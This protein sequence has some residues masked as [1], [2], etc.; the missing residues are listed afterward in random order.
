MREITSII[1]AL[2]A[3]VALAACGGGGTCS[4]SNCAG[5]CDPSGQCQLP[6]D[7]HCGLRGAACSACVGGQRCES[8]LGQCEF[9]GNGTGAGNGAGS[10]SSTTTSA[11]TSG[12]SA[13][14]SG[15]TSTSAGASSGSTGGSTT[16]SISTSSGSTGASSTGSSSGFTSGTSTS[17]SS[18]STGTS[19]SGTSTTTS[20]TTT[21]TSTTGG[22]TTSG[23]TTG[24]TTS[25]STTGTST[26]STSTGG[27][28]QG[29]ADLSGADAFTVRA[30]L[31]FTATADGGPDTSDVTFVFYDAPI[32]CSDVLAVGG[33]VPLA[34]DTIVYGRVTNLYAYPLQGGDYTVPENDHLGVPVDQD[35]LTV[36]HFF[37]D[38]GYLDHAAQNGNI[39][40]N[41]PVNATALTGTFQ[42]GLDD[43]S[44]LLSNGFYAPF[45]MTQ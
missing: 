22:T 44:S 10:T 31:E 7:D 25:G 42:V 8:V 38:G 29:S 14:S 12:T 36:R 3:A 6:A 4:A 11:G 18:T 37:P 9:P 5:C 13:G 35:Q 34:V 26:T 24:T 43:G 32:T 15:S 16:S 19:T 20:T 41:G 40:L 33:A 28:G 23:S 2:A 27:M 1:A 17:T 45:C 30:A 39:H 21:S